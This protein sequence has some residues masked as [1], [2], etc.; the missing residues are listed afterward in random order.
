MK[1]NL[2]IKI[3]VVVMGIFTLLGL[4]G[5]ADKQTS[6]EAYME[7]WLREANLKDTYTKEELYQKS[8]KEDTLVIYSVSSRIFDVKDSFEKEYPGLTVEIKDV[9]GNDIVGQL[10]KNHE[11]ENYQCDLVVCSDN[12]GSL[13]KD[14]IEPGIIYPYIP[15][16]IAPV[17]K[18]GHTS[19]ELIFLGE[20]LMLFYNGEMFDDVP[21]KNIWELTE[22]K[23]K[24]KII[25][26]NPLRSFS[27]YGFSAM[28][29][30]KSEQL[31][32]AYK[33]YAGKE[34]LLSKGETAGEHLWDKVT[35]NAVF[36]SSSDEVAEGIG[37]S[38]QDGYAIGVMISSKM[39]LKELGYN[40]EPIYRLKPFTGVYTPND[41]MM[42]GGAQN[43]NTA[44]LFIRYLLGETDGT[45]EGMLPYSTVGT[46]STRTDVP[47]GNDV[48]L[49]EMDIINLDRE[50]IYENREKLNV[51]FEK[52]LEKNLG[53]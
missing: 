17:M 19:G 34:L 30:Q 3:I 43:I 52:T 4:G 31:A 28:L 7:E 51:L 12:D 26:A 24:G 32:E 47:D 27:T 48:P 20:T 50:Y 5:C 11:E 36:T 37:N 33:E 25:M 22:D 38:G 15:Y 39:R 13:F 45:G 53:K 44:K 14:L 10:Q 29:I 42:A 16:D 1:E 21:I 18:E 6:K 46:W 2:T 23:Y 8:L 40:F 9:R 49:S 41:I 35:Y